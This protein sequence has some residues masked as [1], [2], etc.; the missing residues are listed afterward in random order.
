M[1][2][3]A[4]AASLVHRYRPIGNIGGRF[5]FNLGFAV[6]ES[7]LLGVGRKR[8]VALT[9]EMFGR[10]PLD[11]EVPRLPLSRWRILRTIV[12]EMIHLRQRVRVNR[13]QLPA[14]LAEAPARCAALHAHNHEASSTSELIGLWQDELEP[15]FHAC[16]SMMEA[17]GV[18]PSGSG[19]RCAN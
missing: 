19:T 12:P 17:I 10:I 5:Y 16:C 2:L 4:A 7:A 11:L 13:K 15:F 3:F 8:F 6:S 18:R 1:G 9:E 14:F